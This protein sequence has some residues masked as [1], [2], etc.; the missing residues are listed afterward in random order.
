M[1]R[2]Q[3]NIARPILALYP[4]RRIT[5][6]GP[7]ASQLWRQTKIG[8]YTPCAREPLFGANADG[9]RDHAVQPRAA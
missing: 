8:N 3:M 2:K 7:T 4:K 1:A 5:H 6:T 9:T